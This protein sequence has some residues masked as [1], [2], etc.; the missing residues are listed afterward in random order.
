MRLVGATLLHVDRETDRH[1]NANSCFSHLKC[2]YET[3]RSED[4]PY[5]NYL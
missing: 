4:R 5:E 1:D 2:M 3:W